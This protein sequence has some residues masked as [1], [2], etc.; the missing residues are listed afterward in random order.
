MGSG[1]SPMV[2][3]VLAT[4]GSWLGSPSVTSE[5]LKLAMILRC[6]HLG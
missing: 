3:S 1:R 6:P 2:G 5:S 4:P